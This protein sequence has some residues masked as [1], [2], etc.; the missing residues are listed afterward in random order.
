MNRFSFAIAALTA[1][2]SAGVLSA[3]AIAASVRVEATAPLPSGLY[4]QRSVSV[5]FDDL[6][7]SSTQ[8]ASALYQRIEAASHVACG[9]VLAQRVTSDLQKKYATCRAQ[10]VSGAVAAVNTPSLKEVAAA[11][12]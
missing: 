4:Q 11:I 1:V 10:A 3:G 12:R 8:G 7:V 9:E 6:D 5:S 2:L